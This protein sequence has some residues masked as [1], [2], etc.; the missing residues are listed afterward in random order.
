MPAAAVAPAVPAPTSAPSAPTTAGAARGSPPP[1]TTPVPAPGV[2]P[3]GPAGVDPLKEQSDYQ[4]AFTLLKEGRY[5][6][7]A[8]AFQAFM[9]AYPGGK[10]LDNAQYWLGEAFYVTREFPRSMEEFQ[11][12]VSDYPSSPKIPGAE[13]KIGFIHHELGEPEQARKVLTGLIERYPS[14]TA[15]RLA[16]DRLKRLPAQPSSR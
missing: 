11:K 16:R 15:A 5:E 6:K 13:L 7:A 14:S 4:K 2:A 3:A 9:K 12:L 8:A 1:A 10:Y